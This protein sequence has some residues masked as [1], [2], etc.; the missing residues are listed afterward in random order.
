VTWLLCD[1]GEVLSLAQSP[2]D[3]VAIEK[4]AGRSGSSFWDD[5]WLHRPAYDRANLGVTEYWALVLG[6]PAVDP[7]QLRRLIR[8]DA[9]S[10]LHPNPLSLAAAAQA[11]S[12]G[13]QLAILS[14]APFEVA[15]AIDAADWL[16][17]FSPRLF[18]CRLGAIKPE[19]AA[20]R[21]A[22]DALHAKPQEVIFFDDRPA[23]VAAALALGLRSH[24]FEE[25]QQLADVLP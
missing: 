4:E 20:F 6:V 18:S 2:G 14:N 11:G 24:L 9:A 25:P 10:W 7:D 21:S 16:A 13:L 19:P 8:L 5:Y 3:L 17:G 23:N 22:L 12:R 1:Y 15:D